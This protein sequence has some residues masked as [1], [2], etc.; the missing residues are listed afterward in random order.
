VG[1]NLDPGPGLGLWLVLG[2]SGLSFRCWAGFSQGRVFGQNF[3]G[4][5]Q[6]AAAHPDGGQGQ[7]VVVGGFSLAA[8][9]SALAIH[10]QQPGQ[11]M[12]QGF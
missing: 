11:G 4:L 1:L 8:D 10:F 6:Q 5:G 12:P 3:E 9:M 2:H 7:F